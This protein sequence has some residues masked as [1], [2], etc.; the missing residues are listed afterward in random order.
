MDEKVRR[1]YD[2]YRFAD[3]E[4]Y[5][6]WSIL[7]YADLGSLDNDWINTS[8]NYLVKKALQEADRRF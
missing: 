5:N 2:G 3:I 4:M 7:N 8:S 6:P 1:K